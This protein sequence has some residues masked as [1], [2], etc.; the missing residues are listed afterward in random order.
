MLER[1]RDAYSERLRL[2]AEE[3]A[4]P[5]VAEP[6]VRFVTSPSQ[7]PPLGRRR[8]CA[9]AA[10]L[11]TALYSIARRVLNVIGLSGWPRG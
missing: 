3:F 9:A 10:A 1:G 7:P 11:R 8:G 5:V 4:W 6:L 2:A